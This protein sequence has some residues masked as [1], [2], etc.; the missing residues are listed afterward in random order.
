LK[1][2]FGQAPITDL[3]LEGIDSNQLYDEDRISLIKSFD[4]EEIKSVVF[5]L[6]HNKAACPDGV[7]ADL[8][9][10]LGGHQV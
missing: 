6:K 9:S 8:S 4:L 10:I 1:G 3:R 5:D 7:P 2:L